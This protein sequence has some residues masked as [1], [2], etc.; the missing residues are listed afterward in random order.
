VVERFPSLREYQPYWALRADLCAKLGRRDD[1]YTAYYEAIARED[2]TA[3][4][5]FLE[6]RQARL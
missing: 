2:D 5:A 4:R 1:A 3:V 6:Q